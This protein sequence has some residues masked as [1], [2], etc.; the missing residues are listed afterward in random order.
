MAVTDLT[1]QTLATKLPAGAISVISGEVVINAGLVNGDSISALTDDGVVKFFSM[2]FSAANKA[3]ADAN[4]DQEDGE[5][6]AAFAPATI[7]SN[8]NGLITLSRPFVCRAELATA[9]N[10]IGT[11]V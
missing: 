9:T 6:L 2:L 11:N 3:Q 5:R 1:W 7:G 8:S 10:I 4:V